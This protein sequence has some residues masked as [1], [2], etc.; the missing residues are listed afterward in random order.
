MNPPYVDSVRPPVVLVGGINLVRA[1]GLAGIPVIVASWDP[2]EPALRS[3]YCT[4]Q[5]RLPRPD[6][7]NATANAI[8]ALGEELAGAAGRR[9]PLMY[10]SDGALEL[11]LA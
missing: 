8:A 9:I 11:I 7:G 6:G 3:K 2:D 4:R 5:V 10:G 1:V